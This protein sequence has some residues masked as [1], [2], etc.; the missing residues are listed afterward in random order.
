MEK[1]D[2]AIVITDLQTH[3]KERF[4]ATKSNIEDPHYNK[5]F[6]NGKMEA[7][8]ELHALLLGMES[9][10][11]GERVAA[12]ATVEERKDAIRQ[13]TSLVSAL[14]ERGLIQYGKG[15]PE[16]GDMKGLLRLLKSVVE[17]PDEK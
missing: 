13:A 8:H 6:L 9:E 14:V 11:V 3:L 16:E 1:K 2:E 10:S 5:D 4:E 7:Y 17:W 12:F 15:A